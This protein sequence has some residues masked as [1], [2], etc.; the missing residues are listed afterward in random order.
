VEHVAVRDARIPAVG[1][2]TWQLS[3]DT[4]REAVAH[5][6]ELGYR[7]IDTAR[8][9]GNE[10][11][12]GRGLRDSVVERDEVWVTTKVPGSRGD[13]GGVRDEL[14]ASLRELGTD[15]VD[16][17]LLHQPAPVPIGETMAAFREQQEAGRV[18][19]LGVSNFSVDQLAQADAEAPVVTVQNEYHPG[20][21][22][23]DVL[24]W[25]RA[26]DVALTAYSPLARGSQV[27]D[28]TLAA[29]G[30]RYGKSAAQVA[31]RWL[32]QQDRV[33]TI[34]RSSDAAHRAANLDVFDFRL[35]GE[36][37]ERIGA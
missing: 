29:I 12:V 6:L 4:C 10:A 17:L 26:H 14:E 1:L 7:H 3:G 24:R 27:G 16:L 20:E 30:R 22:Q 33:V 37:M 23:A 15:H 19:H 32:L 35:S 9:Y 13:R 25:C 34:P 8:N 31:I 36:E 5:A 2:G 21:P 18:R 11:E 28:D